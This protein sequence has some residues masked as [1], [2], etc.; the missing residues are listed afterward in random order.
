MR[1]PTSQNHEPRASES[2]TNMITSTTTVMFLLPR[3]KDM[4]NTTVLA[5]AF[6]YDRTVD[7]DTD[8][9]YEPNFGVGLLRRGS[10][11]QESHIERAWDSGTTAN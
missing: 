6:M 11:C 9:V 1:F 10:S 4:I 2:L 7:T 8:T 3:H 5:I